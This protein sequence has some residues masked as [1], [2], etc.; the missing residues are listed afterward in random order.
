MIQ[1]D[2]RIFFRWVGEKPT[3]Q[4]RNPSLWKVDLASASAADAIIALGQARDISEASESF[5]FWPTEIFVVCFFW[6]TEK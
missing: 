5:P 1:F 2:F 3:N 6:P 4:V